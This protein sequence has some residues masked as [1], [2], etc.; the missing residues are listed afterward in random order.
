M[1]PAPRRCRITSQQVSR[2]PLHIRAAGELTQSVPSG[3]IEG[4]SGKQLLDPVR[5][6]FMRSRQN[7]GLWPFRRQ[8]HS[9]PRHKRAKACGQIEGSLILEAYCSFA[10]GDPDKIPESNS[11]RMA[12]HW[13][14][15]SIAAIVCAR[16]SDRDKEPLASKASE[17]CCS[18]ATGLVERVDE[19]VRLVIFEAPEGPPKREI[20]HKPSSLALPNSRPPSLSPR[21]RVELEKDEDTKR[22][23]ASLAKERAQ[24]TN[25]N[26]FEGHLRHPR[27]DVT[28]K[29]AGNRIILPTIPHTYRLEF[30]N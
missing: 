9:V 24:P 25:C 4:G 5:Y 7:N 15:G 2:M 8:T 13:P 19:G 6:L 17:A 30:L 11:L 28:G 22:E 29:N 20:E 14:K 10:Q 26:R 18:T 12:G 3:E 1:L 23:R 16:D 27:L 21:A